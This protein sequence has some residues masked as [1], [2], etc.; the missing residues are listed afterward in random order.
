M[1]IL[2]TFFRV[3]GKKEQKGL[4]SLLPPFVVTSHRY[5]NIGHREKIIRSSRT[6]MKCLQ[7]KKHRQME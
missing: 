1:N 4:N 3:D 5:S 7:D 2:I 6:S